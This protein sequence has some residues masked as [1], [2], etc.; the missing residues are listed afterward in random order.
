MS[1]KLPPESTPEEEFSSIFNKIKEQMWNSFGEEMT[2]IGIIGS[3]NNPE[4]FFISVQPGTSPEK[5]G[6]Y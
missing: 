5:K 6:K 3:P 4:R 2:G 1:E